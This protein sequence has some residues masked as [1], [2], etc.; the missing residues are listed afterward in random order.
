MRVGSERG[1]GNAIETVPAPGLDTERLA[2]QA[3]MSACVRGYLDRL[4][5]SY[6]AVIIL[7]DAYGLT[8]QEVAEA[9]GVS[10]AA[11]KIRI[12]RARARLRSALASGCRFET[13]D[14]GIFVCDPVAR[15]PDCGPDCDCHT[16]SG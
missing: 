15:Q 10:L 1:E 5:D 6:R 9:L 12:H 13:D 7:H 14:R 16:K 8:D 2:E 3:E 4:P 11:A